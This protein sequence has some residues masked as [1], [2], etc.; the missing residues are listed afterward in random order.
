MDRYL[1]WRDDGYLSSNGRCFDIGI[2]VSDALNRYRATGE[3]FA[4]S[5]DPYSARWDK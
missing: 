1:R 3:P 2:T 4:G 5:A